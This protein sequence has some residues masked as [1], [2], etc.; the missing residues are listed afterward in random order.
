MPKRY[1]DIA[2]DG[3]SQVEE[4]QARLRARMAAIRRKVAITSGEGGVGKSVLTA[5]LAAGLAAG[6]WGCWTPT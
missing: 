4:L 3:G 2:G 5:N 1:R 6:G